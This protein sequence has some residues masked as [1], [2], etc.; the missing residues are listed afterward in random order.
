MD[1]CWKGVGGKNG[2]RGS[3]QMQGR[4]QQKG[5][6]RGRGSPVGIEAC[7]RKQEVQNTKMVRRL[8]DKN[9][10]FAL[11]RKC[12]LLRRQ[13]MQEDSKENEGYEIR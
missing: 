8:L 13:R 9:L 5:G 1:Q 7:T 4:E 2:A 12:N 11:F 3:G 6:F 10:F